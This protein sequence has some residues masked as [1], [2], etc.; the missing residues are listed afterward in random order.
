MNVVKTTEIA[1]LDLQ[2]GDMELYVLRKVAS[3]AAAAPPALA[4]AA[5]APAAAAAAPVAMSSL[6][7]ASEP[8]VDET[9][10]CLQSETVGTFRCGRYA[11]GK[12]IGSKPCVEVGTQVKKGQTVAFVEQMG[13][14]APVLANQAGE[15]PRVF[16]AGG[17]P[18]RVRARPRFA[19]PVLRGGHIIGESK[20]V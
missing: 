14:Y 4:P 16:G 1:E 11:K 8:S 18:R 17:R 5:P 13:T 3:S 7:E 15:V 19:L 2:M 10:V 20:H 12:K 9:I 6:E